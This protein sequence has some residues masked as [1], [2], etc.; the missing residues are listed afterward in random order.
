MDLQ[1]Y[2]ANGGWGVGTAAAPELKILYDPNGD[3]QAAECFS[4]P[5]DL[6]SL[7][8]HFCLSTTDCKAPDI[9]DQDGHTWQ[10]VRI[11]YAGMYAICYCEEQPRG[12]RK[13]FDES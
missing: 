13:P 6:Q 3:L 8:G 5:Q 7:A 2:G 10:K 11:F 12:V 9:S 1:L 4:R